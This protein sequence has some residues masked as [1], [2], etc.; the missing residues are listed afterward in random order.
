MCN[1]S[2]TMCCIMYR[3]KH[4]LDSDSWLHKDDFPLNVFAQ[5]TFTACM[6]V[7]KEVIEVCEPNVHAAPKVS[8]KENVIKSKSSMPP[9]PATPMTQ[10]G[11]ALHS[12]KGNDFIY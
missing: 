9:L 12:N 2:R 11:H 5:W 10:S 4:E 8:K 1:G 7:A 6:P 3:A